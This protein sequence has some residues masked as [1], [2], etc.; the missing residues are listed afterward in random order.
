MK[1]HTIKMG[2]LDELNRDFFP[3]PHTPPTSH[4]RTDERS[5]QLEKVVF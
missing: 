5:G 4:S 1:H 2:V 3:K